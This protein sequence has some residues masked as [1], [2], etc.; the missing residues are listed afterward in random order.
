[1]HLTIV[2]ERLAQ[3]L[4]P[5]ALSCVLMLGGEMSTVHADALAYQ[6]LSDNYNP[7]RPI[8]TP[9]DLKYKETN[10][11]RFAGVFFE[12]AVAYQP[13]VATKGTEV[14]MAFYS[15]PPSSLPDAG[16]NRGRAVR[17]LDSIN[18]QTTAPNGD[19]IHT[20]CNPRK[21]ETDE[22]PTCGVWIEGAN[23]TNQYPLFVKLLEE[24]WY[25]R[26]AAAGKSTVSIYGKTYPNIHPL[27]TN[28]PCGQADQIWG[29]ASRRNV[30]SIRGF[31]LKTGKKVQVWALV[32]GAGPTRVFYQFEYPELKKVQ[33][34]GIAVIHCAIAPPAGAETQ[35][36]WR[37]PNDWSI[38][39]P[40]KGC[41]IN[42]PRAREAVAEG[43]PTDLNH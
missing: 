41:D 33:D 12:Q 8:F 13:L 36:D 17:V 38:G 35:P 29:N 21:K 15:G 40:S 34:E 14:H 27:S 23:T 6:S 5:L 11:P 18:S 16:A 30:D 43:Q 31:Y 28:H 3:V 24:H 4:H 32:Q 9:Y 22:P 37:N 42:A 1:M 19:V 39:I 26:A 25:D 20:G 10:D 2:H 7:Y